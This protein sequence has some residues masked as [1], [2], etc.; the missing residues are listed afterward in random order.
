MRKWLWLGLMAAGM[1]GCTS[2]TATGP[3]GE[4]LAVSEDLAAKALPPVKDVPVPIGFEIDDKRSRSFVGTGVRWV[5]HV[6]V[7][8]ADRFAVRRFY[9]KHM[10][11]RRW[12]LMATRFV[13]G[14]IRMEYEKPVPGYVEGCSIDID[15]TDGLFPATEI[16][17]QCYPRGQASGPGA[18]E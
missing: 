16:Y 1:A 10:T 14:R 17:V 13:Q 7:G 11:A 8:K 6:Y 5:D 2:E 12:K 18:G 4:P 3:D 9:E 15:T